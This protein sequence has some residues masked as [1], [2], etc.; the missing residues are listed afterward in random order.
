MNVEKIENIIRL[1]NGDE[2]QEG[3][4]TLGMALIHVASHTGYTKDEMLRAM[5]GQWDLY[6]KV[7]NRLH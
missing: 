1:V 4:A 6:V 7:G 3:L 2:T 5:A